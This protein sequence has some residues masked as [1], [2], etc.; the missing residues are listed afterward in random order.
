MI[1]H[2]DNQI[3]RIFAQLLD[4]GL[5]Q[6][7]IVIF[8]SDNGPHA[9][10]G[11]DPK[12]F[13]ASGGLRGIK[14]DLYEGGIRVPMIVRWPGHI[15]AGKTSTHVGYFGDVMATFAELTGT[16]PPSGIDSLSFLPEL[17]GRPQKKHE[18]LY[19]EF[20]EGGTKQAV[21][22]DQHWKGVRL[23]PSAKMELYDLTTDPG[24]RKDLS[25]TQ[26]EVAQRV[27]KILT[28]SR[29]D[30]PYWPMKEAAAGKKTPAEAK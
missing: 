1:T 24:E 19:W 4:L 10:S 18:S 6:K 28:T 29:T 16:E 22:V 27:E 20:H 9:E 14:R 30:N 5:D 15:A 23:H 7:T 3:G 21:L 11:N 17:L 26:P 13:N 8:A 2:L 25:E 12:F